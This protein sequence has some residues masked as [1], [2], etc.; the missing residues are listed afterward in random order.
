MRDHPLAHKRLML[1]HA[2]SFVDIVTFVVG[3]TSWRSR[4]TV[5]K[6]GGVLREEITCC[7]FMAPRTARKPGTS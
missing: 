7:Q 2:F 6:I 1:N 4:K 5:T 3:E